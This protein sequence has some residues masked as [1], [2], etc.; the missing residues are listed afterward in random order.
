MM[1]KAMLPVF[2]CSHSK[3]NLKIA[4]VSH[5]P[6]YVSEVFLQAPLLCTR[7]ECHLGQ[8]YIFKFICENVVKKK[9][10]ILY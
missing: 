7:D 8:G 9:I 5:F 10:H 2:T 4:R 6:F 1:R 3:L